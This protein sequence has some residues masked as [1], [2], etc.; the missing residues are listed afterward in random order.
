MK[1]LESVVAFARFELTRKDRNRASQLLLE[2]QN[3]Q[4]WIDQIEL[5]GLSGFAYQ[6]T[7]NY[8]LP[9]PDQVVDLLEQ[10][11]SRHTKA[12]QMRHRALGE[13]VLKFG[14]QNI[15][16]L[17]LKGLALAVDLYE[18][19]YLR[20]MRDMDLLVK[21]ADR[22]CAGQALVDLGYSLPDYHP[23][24]FMGSMHQLP[25]A[26][27]K[28]DGLTSSVEV[29]HDGISREV[30]GHFFYPDQVDGLRK[31]DWQGLRFDSLEN[32]T[33]LHQVASHLEGLH[34][35][36]ILKLI[37]VMDVVG[38]AGKLVN[39][40]DWKRV[41]RE[42][43]H[44][45]NTLKCLHLWTPLPQELLSLTGNSPKKE[46]KGV[47]QIM[48]SLRAGVNA[49]SIKEKF[50]LLFLPS[51]WWLHLHY[52]VDPSNRLV[53]TKLLRH[54][55]KVISWFFDRVMSFISYIIFQGSAR[56]DKSPSAKVF[57]ND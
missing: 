17:A 8:Q 49:P 30:S 55:F 26:M 14:E 35:G 40:H 7:L 13:I 22:Q 12:S 23:S 32:V 50:R 51:D 53:T 3:W 34:T 47:G 19:E 28:I 38:L 29:H 36:A 2:Q 20:P 15:S 44:V 24:R 4:H 25:N 43:P 33:M 27:K 10:L 54:P 5:H 46:L 42:Y 9:V 37:N 6:H 41:E 21:R 45:I 56:I 57:R 16:F 31:L 1:A 18:F 48:S 11:K 39:R 52:H